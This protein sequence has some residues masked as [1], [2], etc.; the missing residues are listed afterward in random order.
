MLIS[1]E[2]KGCFTWFIYFLDLLWVRYNCAKFHHCKI[3]VT[4]FKK[5]GKGGGELFH[6]S[7]HPWAAPKKPILNRI[8]CSST[9]LFC[10]N[11]TTWLLTSKVL[12][13]AN[14][15]GNS[16]VY[17]CLTFS[18]VVGAF[19]NQLECMVRM[20]APKQS[21]VFQFKNEEC[22]TNFMYPNGHLFFKLKMTNE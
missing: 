20:H 5:V 11:T 8:K 9:H 10:K 16:L 4:D 2:L 14:R 19:K 22:K 15:V 6:L 18:P 1:A 12:F 13:S 21:F 17:C 7:P 3:C